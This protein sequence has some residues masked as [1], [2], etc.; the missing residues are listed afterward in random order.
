MEDWG[1]VMLVTNEKYVVGHDCSQIALFTTILY[2][3]LA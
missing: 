1:I 3:S 2:A